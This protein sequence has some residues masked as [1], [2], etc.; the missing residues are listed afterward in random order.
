MVTGNIET[1]VQFIFRSVT[2]GI[3]MMSGTGIMI[4]SS[5]L[6]LMVT[7]ILVTLYKHRKEVQ[8]VSHI[9]GRNY[10]F[11]LLF[12]LFHKNDFFWND[13]K[14]YHNYNEFGPYWRITVGDKTIFHT[15]KLDH[16]KEIAITKT[17][18][19]EKDEEK[20]N[21]VDQP[22]MFLHREEENL[23]RDTDPYLQLA[24]QIPNLQTT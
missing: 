8:R 11:K 1:L 16:Y 23:G 22:T 10:P 15:C 20:F 24:L 13:K 12:I 4:L 5:F 17:K 3:N 19:F 7:Y 6:A 2:P 18:Y 21:L 9:P 14:Q